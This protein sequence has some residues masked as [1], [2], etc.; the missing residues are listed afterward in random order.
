MNTNHDD[1][2]GDLIHEAALIDEFHPY[3][4]KAITSLFERVFL[5]AARNRPQAKRIED[6]FFHVCP[7]Q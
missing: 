6:H 4:C 2:I 5:T 7:G 3:Q 1:I